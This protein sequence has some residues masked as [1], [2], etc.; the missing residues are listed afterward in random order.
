MPDDAPPQSSAAYGQGQADRQAWETWFSAQTGNARAGALYW[1]G[2]RSLTKPGTCSP[3]PSST[4][5]DWTTGCYAAQ[6]KLAAS[7]VRRKAEPAYRLG[8]NNP[9]LAPAP[10]EDSKVSVATSAPTAAGGSGETPAAATPA[11]LGWLGVRVQEVAPEIAESLGLPA[12]EGALVVSLTPGGPAEVVG[13]KRG[14]VIQSY[15]GRPIVRMRDLLLAVDRTQVDQR[16]PVTVWRDGRVLT[17][18]P[19]IETASNE[20]HTDPGNAIPTQ[21]SAQASASAQSPASP[22]SSYPI[23]QVKNG[24][25][26]LGSLSNGEILLIGI[27]VGAVVIYFLP[28]LIGFKRGISS[29]GALFFVNLIFGWTFIGWLVC[30]LWAAIGATR[31]QDEFFRRE[32]SRNA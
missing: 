14:D 16:V 25:G 30:F 28:A 26:T 19:A 20:G 2:Q 12:A 15:G 31:A 4:G 29:G 6:Q 24:D 22:A 27:V 8:W 17:L 32:G 5:P 9:S 1:S 18:T 7:D 11:Q 21:P 3:F 13:I 10:A 23:G